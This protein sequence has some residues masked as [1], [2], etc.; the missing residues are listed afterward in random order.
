M[1]SQPLSFALPSF[2]K[3]MFSLGFVHDGACYMRDAHLDKHVC[4]V[5][6]LGWLNILFCRFEPAANMPNA[7]HAY[8]TGI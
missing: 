7:A 6:R 2:P 8:G 3:L 5:S 1:R 4:C